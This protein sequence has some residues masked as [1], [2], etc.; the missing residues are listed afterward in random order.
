MNIIKVCPLKET[1]V[2]LCFLV[3]SCICCFSADRN[4]M[5]IIEK[6]CNVWDKVQSVSYEAKIDSI[7]VPIDEKTDA[8]SPEQG[9]H[10]QTLISYSSMG[11]SFLFKRNNK[12]N[13]TNKIYED[14]FSFH[15]GKFFRLNAEDQTLY[16][17]VKLKVP[18]SMADDECLIRSYFSFLVNKATDIIHPMLR[19]CDLKSIHMDID[20]P[21]LRDLAVTETLFDNNLPILKIGPI[22]RD[23]GEKLY[24]YLDKATL[25]PYGLDRHFPGDN[26]IIKIRT[27]T[28]SEKNGFK[29]P[30]ISVREVVNKTKNIKRID[31]RTISSIKFNAD[32]PSETFF[33]DPANARVFADMDNDTGF[34]MPTD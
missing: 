10:S 3:S 26:L 9:I 17:G 7:L 28:L 32:I 14:W 11:E 21:L 4:A 19:I 20:S 33:I 27:K 16:T 12:I 24:V 22:N 18:D 8:S 23:A 13:K 2:F 15:E 29:Y 30:E 25:F 31:T 34:S 1:V 5:T 6:S